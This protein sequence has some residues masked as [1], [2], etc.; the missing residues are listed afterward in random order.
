MRSGEVAL[1]CEVCGV[2]GLRVEEFRVW[3][4][5]VE[6][7]GFEVKGLQFKIQSDHFWGADGILVISLFWCLFVGTSIYGN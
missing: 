3:G 5:R 1:N 7:L 2:G 4:W 6:G